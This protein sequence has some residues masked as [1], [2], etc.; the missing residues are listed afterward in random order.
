MTTIPATLVNAAVVASV[1]TIK[2]SCLMA[3]TVTKTVIAKVPPTVAVAALS[4][5]L[6]HPGDVRQRPRFGGIATKTTA[7]HVLLGCV[8]VVAS[9]RTGME[10]CRMVIIVTKMGT[11]N[12][13]PTVTAAALSADLANLGH[14]RRRPG[15]DREPRL[16]TFRA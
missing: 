4:A 15:M 10:S 5:D 7:T 2:V 3:S 9:V 16:G 12:L 8:A 1:Q 13:A 14:V 6:A 11:V